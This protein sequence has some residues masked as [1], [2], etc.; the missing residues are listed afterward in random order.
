MCAWT[1]SLVT[2][3]DGS[4][5]LRRFFESQKIEE[6]SYVVTDLGWMSHLVSPV[7]RVLVATTHASSL[8]EASL[9]EIG[10]DPLGLPMRACA[11]NASVRSRHAKTHSSIARP[12]R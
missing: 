10:H 5:R 7:Y 2:E 9:D 3:S 1:P 8:E 11:A 4:L 12:D 6:S